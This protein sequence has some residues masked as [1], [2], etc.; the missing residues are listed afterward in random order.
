MPHDRRG[1]QSGPSREPPELERV[2]LAPD[3][4]AASVE[5]MILWLV[6]D[7]VPDAL[8]GFFN[9]ATLSGSAQCLVP[10]SILA[11]AALWLARRRVEALL[12][13]ASMVAA[14]M[15]IYALKAAVDRARPALWEA[16]WYWGSS[17]PSGH[18]LAV[19]TFATGA[20]LCAARIQP[21]R[22]GLVFGLAA[23]AVF[24]TLAVG[25]SRLT[26]GV[27]WPSDVLASIALGVAIPVSFCKLFDLH[28]RQ[29]KQKK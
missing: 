9:I 16:P 11:T 1:S 4:A 27:H 14:P 10:A 3:T 7:H 18:T 22:H 29:R 12:M 26:I 20:V 2:T 5:A 13:G 28:Q 6:H 23:L 15:T 24:W 17:F 21:H 25:M 19:A 8:T